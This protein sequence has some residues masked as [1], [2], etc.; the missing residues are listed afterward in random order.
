MDPV[1]SN[2]VNTNTLAYVAELSKSLN[3]DIEEIRHELGA[4]LLSRS[5][6][7]SSN[8]E[9]HIV[10]SIAD[11]LEKNKNL[12]KEI[13]LDQR[14]S[15]SEK[16]KLLQLFTPPY[17]LKFSHNPND[18]GS[19][20]YYRALNEIGT[21]RCYDLLGNEKIPSGYD[22]LIKEVGCNISKLV[23]YNRD[24]VHGCTPILSVDD[25]IRAA[26][27][28]RSL[29]NYVINGDKS[30][31]KLSKLFLHDPIYR[32]IQKSEHC[33]VKAKYI[34]FAHSVYDITTRGMADVM[35]AAS[36]YRGIGFIHYS[37]KILSNLTSGSDEGLNWKIEIRRN[38]TLN[39]GK[40]QQYIMFWFDNDYQNAYVH[41]LDTYLGIIR[42][43]K[44][45]SSK[46]V[47]YLIQRTEEI[48]GLLFFSIIRPIAPMGRFISV[49]NSSIVRKIPF[50]DP[51]NVI[52]HY[53]TLQNDPS[54]YNYHD[55][56]P[57]RLVVP[58]PYFAKLYQF[59]FMLPDGKFTTQNAISFASTMS[60][61]TVVNGAYVTQP[62]KLDTDTVDYTAFAVYF[63]VYCRRYDLLKVL[64]KLK[65]FE[66]LKRNPTIF[67]RFVAL[68]KSVG[69]FVFS[70]RFTEYVKEDKFEDAITNAKTELDNQYH[71]THSKNILQ[72]IMKLFRI[73]NKYTVRYFPITRVVS[74]E[75]DIQFVSDLAQS[76]P[77]VIPE[78]N[79]D[80]VLET[81][82]ECLKI[83]RIE[84]H[85]CSIDQGYDCQDNLLEIPNNFKYSCL[86]KCFC[87][88]HNIAF[89]D[90][91]I[92]LLKSQLFENL[93]PTLQNL[94][95]NSIEGKY[96]DIRLFELIACVFSVNV[97]LHCESS[98]TLYNTNSMTT[99]HFSIKD[100]HC[101]E[102]RKK[103][104]IS[105]FEFSSQL[106]FEKE[107]NANF[108]QAYQSP[109]SEKYKLYR[110]VTESFSPYVA[111]SVLKLHE[112][113]GNYGVLRT[114][115]ICELSAAP[116][117]WL[118]YADLHY[119]QSQLFYSHY[120]GNTG[121]DFLFHS[122]K[123]TLLNETTKG[124]LAST[125]DFHEISNAI[126]HHGMMDVILSDAFIPKP[127]EDVVDAIVFSEYQKTFFDSLIY[128]LK[129]DGNVVFKTFSDVSISDTTS[130]IL[131]KFKT[132]V[133]CKPNF[134]SPISTEY[135]IVAKGFSRESS[136]MPPIDYTFIPNL[137][138]NRVARACDA[139]I[140]KRF[141]VQIK[142]S[143]PHP[144]S[145]IPVE[146][147]ENTSPTAP[148]LE[149]DE[150]INTSD[151][152]PAVTFESE[153]TKY[154][155][156]MEFLDMVTPTQVVRS[157]Q[158]PDSIPDV[159]VVV[160]DTNLLDNLG[161]ETTYLLHDS[162][163]V[164][165]E[166][167]ADPLVTLLSRISFIA[168]KI[169]TFKLRVHFDLMNIRD[170]ALIE[171]IVSL[172]INKFSLHGLYIIAPIASNN[173]PLNI[174]DKSIVE[175][176]TYLRALSAAN[177][178][179]YNTLYTAFKNN[180]YL[181]THTFKA[182]LAV[183]IQ[184]VSVLKGDKFMFKHPRL[185][186]KYTHAYDG[187]DRVF[188]PFSHCQ[189]N[190]SKYY[191]V[192]EYTFCMFDDQI[193]ETL[194]SVD[195]NALSTVQFILVQ[196]VA[197]HGKTTEIVQK[198]VPSTKSTSGDLV[199]APTKA[200][201]DVIRQRTIQHY[202][203]DANNL[204]K[205]C[206]RTMA[207]YLL[208]LKDRKYDTVF[209]DEA[210]MAHASYILAVAFYSGART[211]YMYGDTAQIPFHSAL[212]DVKLYYHSPQSM[213]T[214][215]HIRNKSY[216][217][218][219]DVA[220]AL[221]EE[222][223]ECHKR[224]GSNLGIITASPV[225]RSLEVIKINDISFMKSC[226]NESFKYLT[227]TH[228]ACNDLK[229]LDSKFDVSTIA[230]YQGS[231]HPN[232]AI[233]RT[234][235]SEADQIYNNSPLCV[236]A[237]TRHTK[238]LIYY[239][240][241]EKDD[242]LSNLIKYTK[243]VTDLKIK[244][245]STSCVVGSVD[246]PF[247]AVD[248]IYPSYDANS[249]SKFFKSKNGFSKN[250]TLIRTD[251]VHTEKEFA[252]KCIPI[253]NDI[254]VTKDIFKNLSMS[255]MIKWTRKLAPHVKRIHV[256][257]QNEP[258]IDNSA[259]ND[260]VE[261]YK[262]KN[263]IP[264]VPSQSLNV[265]YTPDIA[266]P[267]FK[268]SVFDIPP[269]IEMLQT[270]MSHLYPNC[271]YIPRQYDA[272]FV[273]NNDISLTLSNV[274][275]NFNISNYR[276]PI[277]DSLRPILSTPAPYTRDVTVLE[278]L[279][280][281]A[282]RNLN[283]PELIENVCSDDVS[284]HL[285]QNFKKCLIPNVRKILV[286]L[287]PIIPTTDSII[288]WLE[289]QDRSVLKLIID[290]IPLQCADLSRCAFSLKRTPKVRITPNAVDIYD[291]VQTITCH[292]KFVNAYF[293][294]IV[295][296]AQDRLMKLMLPYFKMFTKVT[297]EDFGKE[298]F[299]IWTH[300]GKL[301][302]FSGDDSLLIN[303]HSFK[304]MDM[305][306]FDK[307]QLIFALSFLCKLFVYLGV[308]TYIAQLYYEMMYY[309]TCSNPLNKVTLRL[310]PQMESGS[311]ATYFGNTCFC[312]AV[313]LSSIE[314]IGFEFLPRFEKMAQ[315]F[316]LEVKEFK[317]VNPY[318][319]S[320][321]MVIS[322]T[323]IRFYPD[324][325]KILIKLGRTDLK[326]FRHLREFHTSLKDLLSQYDDHL[327]IAM[328]SAA[329]RE[330]Y[331]FGYDCTGH[332]LNLISVIRND[333]AFHSLYFSLPT[334]ILDTEAV[335]Y[336]EE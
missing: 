2:D 167:S 9:N 292:P 286:D 295:E 127:D 272:H 193:A 270:F 315:M 334:D 246:F 46:G 242:H 225:I 155:N 132:V 14:L 171:K 88:T 81:I 274:T 226:F 1:D 164:F 15:D 178:N 328:I 57:I 156:K 107:S 260:L 325:I 30:Q 79:Q 18:I 20:L 77:Y 234:S 308:P 72:W 170:I 50:S 241:C 102:L 42:N 305:S 82:S 58:T 207:S 92:K 55:L 259:V 313:V 236:T 44:C 52:I 54:K 112:I 93:F 4:K 264:T 163:F 255:E 288:S 179:S 269:S 32:C 304:E 80:L 251:S 96:A 17:K 145:I 13:R 312:M 258:F 229:K 201:I 190:P 267:Q 177:S 232:I 5:A 303:G 161:S 83:S 266:P 105:P 53:Y 8:F 233:L 65:E 95:R 249:V 37:S 194:L 240:M 49:P 36:A 62:Y 23:K 265:I 148:L 215:S 125:D 293:C 263:C 198:H 185:R 204:D 85:Q 320:K 106:R 157:P 245:F 133:C 16:S 73:K 333:E 114:G 302:L 197:G 214:A 220:C 181:L 331:G 67:N 120:T 208:N 276:I 129:E 64:S 94:L 212:G 97:C 98:C 289:R 172:I 26:N 237:I 254:F 87:N 138:H 307:S 160:Y 130:L 297:T 186:E 326:N 211:V 103:L 280:G 182:N 162:E 279:L 299:D 287:D 108:Q 24:N 252:T 147:E 11:T 200:S 180:Q 169:A 262:I 61:R 227:F 118:Q 278:L 75:E 25:V 154:I 116:G 22:V 68:I 335:R 231:E 100:G 217:I 250:F 28:E 126:S 268:E 322:D 137:A 45:V 39:L 33:R 196:G 175:Y 124:D 165:V 327:D 78:D 34:V 10:D 19:H 283:P 209:I 321:F 12:K 219:A 115:K 188:V 90:L 230:S 306:K 174:F 144:L 310:T 195:T 51:D 228:T 140:N 136:D 256:K 60:S 59:L 210:I 282:K 206:Y 43:T 69:S 176:T 41:E 257:V 35:D 70:S 66:D 317:Y 128:W 153:L 281:A 109:S 122:D 216:R 48:G 151:D 275:A 3:V 110:V 318:F 324:P 218:P 149:E 63:I 166:L 300:Y 314:L 71:L 74:L 21:Y 150:D 47:E 119:S 91:K 6:I 27:T 309:R 192:G 213:F 121:C 221:D 319:C 323:R 285:L 238:K 29:H 184:S 135:Y 173:I 291:S 329:I 239:T 113:D 84:T 298:C 253:H 261:D 56:I 243:S 202:K 183:D 191:L 223:R 38:G 187:E 142:Y 89:S 205:D 296:K 235:L 123:L 139:L 158:R 277:Y 199:V 159:R 104:T 86:L 143:I 189:C 152:I 248:T 244:S 203:I 111:R 294:S 168:V 284:D 117:S 330:R 31:K 332:I 146:P 290:D 131:N 271:V 7:L 301:Y 40:I 141:P 336:T 224:N 99:Y 247:K 311:A 101:S 273:H 316:N 134:S 76:V 222:Y